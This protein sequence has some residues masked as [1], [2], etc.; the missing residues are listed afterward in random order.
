MLNYDKYIVS[1]SGGKDSIWC[2]L[3]LLEIGVPRSKIELW[4]NSI[5]GDTPGSFMDWPVTEDYCRVF[6]QHLG[7]P[8]Y[9]S[10]REG[11]FEREMLRDNQATARTLFEVPTEE[12]TII[13]TAGGNGPLNT[14]R[15]FPQLSAS[16]ATRLMAINI[17]SPRT[18][19]LM[20]N[21]SHSQ[22]PQATISHNTHM[23]SQQ[24]KCC[25][26]IAF[27]GLATTSFLREHQLLHVLINYPPCIKKE[28]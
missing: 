23:R 18:S 10:W 27:Y 14:R 13:R 6:A 20:P 4:H 19:F 21:L 2:V 15:K 24:G 25:R 22:Q 1:F 28:N 12:G 7:L 11:G 5:D 16:L 26:K 8:I 17:I 9:F 3:H